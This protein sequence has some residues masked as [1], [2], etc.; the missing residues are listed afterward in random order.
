M[1]QKEKSAEMEEGEEG[2]GEYLVGSDGVYWS[3]WQLRLFHLVIQL[4]SHLLD[5]PASNSGA[6]A[7]T[8]K[9]KVMDPQRQASSTRLQPGKIGG[10][11]GFRCASALAPT[12]Q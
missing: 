3:M 2:S 4:F 1:K 10:F 6:Q 9:G 8:Q 5:V 7:R 12:L 11:S